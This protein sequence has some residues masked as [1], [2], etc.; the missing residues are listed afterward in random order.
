MFTPIEVQ[1][2]FGAFTPR[3]GGEKNAFVGR[4]VSQSK[5]TSVSVSGD[6]N[7]NPMQIVV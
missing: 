2:G 6:S 4:Q 3:N 5:S 1:M 7:A